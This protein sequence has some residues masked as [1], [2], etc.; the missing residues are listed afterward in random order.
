MQSQGV[1]SAVATDLTYNNK[2]IA[3]LLGGYP[4]IT[5]PADSGT[6]TKAVEVTLAAQKRLSFSSL[7]MNS[8]PTI[9][10]T[11]RAALIS[12][13]DYCVLSL[14]PT[15]ATGLTMWGNASANL[16]CGM[17]TN[18][19]SLNA[20]AAGG[21][22]DVT[23]SPIAAVGGIQ[24]NSHYADGTQFSPFSPAMAD[25]FANVIAPAPSGPCNS[26][27]NVKPSKTLTLSPGCYTG[28]TIKGD[29]TL[30]PGTYFIDGG[31]INFNSGANITGEGVTLVLSNS[32][33]SSTAT[34]GTINM[35]GGANLNLTAP[36]S[37]NYA[38]IAFYPG[39]SCRER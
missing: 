33:S 7:F 32:S 6:Y 14:E 10:A 31:D 15:S 11:A 35:N 1:N 3:A 23:A 37:G 29:V 27:P 24:A 5:L 13:G 21:S 2:T 26:D 16:G 36:D 19:T 25:P 39:S 28:L 18:S 30:E 17:M 12:G 8:P 4:Q 38:G 22:A 34:I 9:T 20:A